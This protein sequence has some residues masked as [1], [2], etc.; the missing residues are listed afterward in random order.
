[1]EESLSWVINLE[2]R[3]RNIQS[4]LTAGG[5]VNCSIAAN[6]MMYEGKVKQARDYFKRALELTNPSSHWYQYTVI[7]LAN[8]DDAVKIAR[9]FWELN[10]K[11]KVS[12]FLNRSEVVR[13][14]ATE[15]YCALPADDENA[16]LVIVDRIP[17]R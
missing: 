5:G 10:G 17:D 1:L 6:V 16:E 9:R 7:V 4:L 15:S 14:N 2:P 12:E 3:N 11:G 8:F 13:R